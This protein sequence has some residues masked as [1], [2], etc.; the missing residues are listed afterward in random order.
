MQKLRICYSKCFMGLPETG[1]GSI[2]K[3]V[4]HIE[5]NIFQ[6]SPMKREIPASHTL[7]ALTLSHTDSS[8]SPEIFFSST[9]ARPSCHFLLPAP[10]EGPS[11]PSFSFQRTDCRTAVS[12]PIPGDSM[13]TLRRRW[14]QGQQAMP[15]SLDWPLGGTGLGLPKLLGAGAWVWWRT[16]GDRGRVLT[17][18]S[19]ALCTSRKPPHSERKAKSIERRQED[20]SGHTTSFQ[21]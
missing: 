12:Y 13:K 6:H 3:G 10:G 19:Q 15:V 4:A 20:L 14:C 8:P 7:S 16:M 21:K 1:L 9:S 5:K 18:W 11:L 17:L 2:Q